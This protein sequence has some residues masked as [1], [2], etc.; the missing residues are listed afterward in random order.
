LRLG[1]S[2]STVGFGEY[3]HYT[4]GQ[5][6]QGALIDFWRC[7]LE[8]EP[9]SLEFVVRPYL[10]TQHEI[11]QG[12]LDIYLSTFRVAGLRPELYTDT[13]LSIY[14]SVISLAENKDLLAD[15]VWQQQAVGVVKRSSYHEYLKQQGATIGAR[16]ANMEQLLTLL[17]RGR[18]SVISLPLT[19]PAEDSKRFLGAPLAS[20]GLLEKTL[21]GAIS[22]R[23]HAAD[24]QLIER[25][26]QRIPT[27]ESALAQIRKSKLQ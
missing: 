6:M 25:V 4:P 26:N 21:Y 15:G 18:L 11:A 17:V 13:F 2:S 20:R 1:V 14:V 24:P 7:V 19:W 5:P 3:A 9:Q 22:P 8:P 23:R 27:C 10:R 12:E 16:V